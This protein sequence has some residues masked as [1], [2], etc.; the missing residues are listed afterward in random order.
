MN[1]LYT[2]ARA[3]LNIATKLWPVVFIPLITTLIT[4]FVPLF[5]QAK[6]GDA[7]YVF[8]APGRYVQLLSS[9]PASCSACLYYF[10]SLCG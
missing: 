2:I 8:I 4:V 7:L 1:I 6:P 10:P 3:T 9:S 5:V